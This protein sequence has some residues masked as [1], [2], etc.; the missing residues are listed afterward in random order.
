MMS[1]LTGKWQSEQFRKDTHD[2]QAD[3]KMAKRTI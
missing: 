2:V 3:W 1:K